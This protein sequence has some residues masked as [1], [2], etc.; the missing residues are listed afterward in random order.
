VELIWGACRA[1][2]KLLIGGFRMKHLNEFEIEVFL[3][4][5]EMDKH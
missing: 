2:R 4:I 5:Y 3:T 1:L